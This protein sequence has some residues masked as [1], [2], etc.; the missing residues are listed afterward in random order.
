MW[1]NVHPYLVWVDALWM[2]HSTHTLSWTT[3]DNFYYSRE[4]ASITSGAVG[5]TVAFVSLNTIPLL[6]FFSFLKLSITFAF[7]RPSKKFW[8]IDLEYKLVLLNTSIKMKYSIFFSPAMLILI[9]LLPDTF[10]Y[11]Q[12]D[13]CT[14]LFP[15]VVCNCKTLGK[16]VH[17]YGINKINYWWNIMQL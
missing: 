1:F 7:L 2:L 10:M 16:T 12:S 9:F 13:R 8:G 17:R 4:A 15:I 14:S 11:V 6:P 3:P 5:D